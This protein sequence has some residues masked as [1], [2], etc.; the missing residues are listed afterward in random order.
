MTKIKYKLLLGSACLAII[1]IGNPYAVM[2]EDCTGVLPGADCTLDENTTAPLTIDGGVTLTVG[3]S[4][5]IGHEIDAET[6]AGDGSIATFGLGNNI[7]QN[8]DIG[9]NLSID[10]LVISDDNTWTTSARIVT[11]S[12]GADID[13]GAADGGETLN[14]LS[15]GSYI[16]EIDGHTG[17]TVNFGSDGLGGNYATGGQIETVT[18]IVTSG[19][20][21]TNNTVGGGTPLGGFTIA[22]G[23]S[24]IQNANITN[25]GALDL[26][27]TLTIGAGDIFSTNT[28]VADAN[29]GT[30]IL[31]LKREAGTTESGTLSVAAGGPLDLS[32]DIV[33]IQLDS[34]SQKFVSEIVNNILVGNTGAAIAPAQFIGN[35]FLY[36]FSLQPNGNNFN[37]VI[38]AKSIDGLTST[39]N[40]FAVAN[41]I[42]NILADSE[43]NDI[44]QAQSLLGSAATQDEFNRRLESLQPTIDGGYVVA[45]MAASKQLNESGLNRIHQLYGGRRPVI[46]ENNKLVSGSRDLVTGRTI[47]QQSNKIGFNEVGTM[48]A[49]AYTH[50]SS[51]SEKDGIQGFDASGSGIVIGADTGT[52]HDKLLFGMSVLAGNTDIESDNS[53]SSKN[54]VGS[55]GVSVFGGSLVSAK[56][57]LS[58][59]L[60]Y[61]HNQNDT[62]RY[63]LAGLAGNNVTGEFTTEHISLNSDLAYKYKTV[64][65]LTITPSASFSYDYL[66]AKSYLEKGDTDLAMLVDY[67]DMH[68]MALGMGVDLDYIYKLSNGMT[69]YPSGYMKY[70]Y[71]FLTDGIESYASYRGTPD[72]KLNTKG[73]E[74]QRS[75]INIGTGV[76]ADIAKDWKV[77]LGYD[78]EYK[79]KYNSHTGHINA[80]H[81][82]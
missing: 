10:E 71:D 73:Y 59:S 82:F 66:N 17:D 6:A 21:T 75:S 2:A 15:G 8:A 32:N 24:V 62:T 36:D 4:I 50:S 44:N 58:G 1:G 67:N 57:L 56:T 22:D 39:A 40:N 63:N 81:K 76:E 77:A 60:S 51:Q 52:M 47:N 16:G 30:I 61:V 41:T 70:K 48:W 29:S 11:N 68:M 5:L 31:K 19:S 7:T 12:S 65:D 34:G 14:F 72:I 27:G 43:S 79:D 23:A 49:Q 45:S 25:G 55:Y 3:G 35:S 42:L 33:Q 54:E 64:N 37:L 38:V 78:F 46:P 18:I 74:P 20:L 26:D 28:Y 13:L 80:L 53:N 9:S 69:L